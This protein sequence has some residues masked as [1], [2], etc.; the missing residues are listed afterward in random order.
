MAI[1]YRYGFLH[2]QV[3]IA[4]FSDILYSCTLKNVDNLICRVTYSICKG[5]IPR[6]KDKAGDLVGSQLAMTIR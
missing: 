5:Q 1:T 3:A 4:C 6:K 2:N